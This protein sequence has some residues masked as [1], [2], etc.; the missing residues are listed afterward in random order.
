M[1]ERMPQT[2]YES[3]LRS[4]ALHLLSLRPH[5]LDFR[6][7]KSLFLSPDFVA[8]NY[9]FSGLFFSPTFFFRGIFTPYCGGA[10]GTTQG[11]FPNIC[12]NDG[13]ASVIQSSDACGFFLF[14]FSDSFFS[15]SHVLFINKTSLTQ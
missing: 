5:L 6:L 9:H 13:F 10:Y 1:P 4:G 7:P 8:F 15:V 2:S 14:P 12:W 3:V 11:P